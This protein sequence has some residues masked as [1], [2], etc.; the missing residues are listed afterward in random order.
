MSDLADLIG[1]RSML[2]PL[3]TWLTGWASNAPPALRVAVITGEAGVGKTTAAIALCK[4]AGFAPEIEESGDF[5]RLNEIA[6]KPTFF[7]ERR[8]AILDDANNLSQKIWNQILKIGDLPFPLIIIASDLEQIFWRIRRSALTI[9]VNT[10]S[11]DQIRIFLD[12]ERDRIG[13]DHTDHDLDRIASLSIS[14]RSARL[15]LLT[16]PPN[17]DLDQ[18]IRIPA[19]IGR[20]QIQ[21]ILSGSPTHSRIGVHPMALIST[22]LWNGSNPDHVIRANTFH[23]LSWN[24]EGLA[25]ISDAYLTTIRSISTDNP[26]FRSRKIGSHRSLKRV[27]L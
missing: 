25:R 19:K 15:T 22:A 21:A 3:R 11:Q 16:T 23:S 12:R 5:D 7:G 1:P 18:E 9:R 17:F 6:R 4:A 8:A 27:G 14:W 24:V 26:P 20:S 2:Q 10:P 13:S